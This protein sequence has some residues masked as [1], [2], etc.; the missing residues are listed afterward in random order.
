M[1][2]VFSSDKRN[3]YIQTDKRADHLDEP[4]IYIA[5]VTHGRIVSQQVN[6]VQKQSARSVLHSSDDL[7]QIF[8]ELNAT[9]DGK[10]A[11]HWKA[12][13]F[14]A[15]SGTLFTLHPF[16]QDEV[17]EHLARVAPV[18]KDAQQLVMCLTLGT[19]IRTEDGEKLIEDIQV[20]DNVVTLD[21]GLQPVRWI[22]S[23]RVRAVG[24][25]LPIRIAKDVFRSG[26][27]SA[28]LMVSPK[29]R[30]VIRGWQAEVLFGQEEVLCTAQSLLN[31]TTITRATDLS[32]VE[33]FH[34]LFDSHQ[35][36]YANN[37]LTESFNPSEVALYE[38]DAVIREEIFA[39]FPELQDNPDFYGPSVRMVV[40]GKEAL[41][42][43]ES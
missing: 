22:G 17:T 23:R 21:S 30:V 27:P 28:D 20:G 3:W 10:V 14:D 1:P 34:L 7:E 31:D 18:N 9:P 35:L 5:S 29:H 8:Q 37:A 19:S 33:Y 40:T 26:S 25:M 2:V 43:W 11:A 16:D 39:I 32:E 38:I 12:R 24:G 13:E 41:L 4:K 6:A 15:F 36:I 42:I